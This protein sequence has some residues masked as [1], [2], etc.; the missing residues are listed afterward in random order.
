MHEEKYEKKNFQEI[1][2]YANTFIEEKPF[3]L[4]KI[5]KDIWNTYSVN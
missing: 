2:R 4:F 5:V 3:K 1:G